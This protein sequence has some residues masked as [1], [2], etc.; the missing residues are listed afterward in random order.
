MPG[1]RTI[2]ETAMKKA[3]SLAWD[4][5]FKEAVN[6]YRRAIEEFPND[7]A[8]RTSLASTLRKLGALNDAIAEY[9]IAIKL[10]PD[11][12]RLLNMLAEVQQQAGNREAAAQTYSRIALLQQREQ[13]LQA[14]VKSFQTAIQLDPKNVDAHVGLSIYY[15]S[16]RQTDAAV[17]ELLTVGRLLALQAKG[18]EAAEYVERALKLSPNNPEAKDLLQRIRDGRV[19]QS[20]PQNQPAP[21][22]P[23]PTNLKPTGSEPGSGRK[24]DFQSIISGNQS[25][26]SIS[27]TS[28]ALPQMPG[29]VAIP[30]MKRKPQPIG[31]AVQNFTQSPEAL[32]QAAQQ[33]EIAGQHYIAIAFHEAIL[34]QVPDNTLS[35]MALGGLYR[36]VEQPEQA[37]RYYYTAMASPRLKRSAM[38]GLG[39]ALREAGKLDET[40]PV[41]EEVANQLDL[42]TLTKEE[43]GEAWA[44]ARALAECYLARGETNK[45]TNVSRIFLEHCTAHG[46]NGLADQIRRWGL[47]LSGYDNGAWWADVQTLPAPERLPAID[48]M[49]RSYELTEAKLWRGAE[50]I[51]LNHI[52]RNPDFLPVHVR[53]GEIYQRQ[54]RN[55][56]ALAKYSNVIDVYAVRGDTTPTIAMYKRVLELTPDNITMRARLAK[57][58][59]D[60]RR[61]EESA[62]ES[63]AV[64]ASYARMGQVE[65]AMDEYRRI[66]NLFPHNSVAYLAYG[67]T[68]NRLGRGA[69]ALQAY[70]QAL[71]LDPN[72]AIAATMVVIGYAIQNEWANIQP[73]FPQVSNAVRTDPATA[74]K[75][76]KEFVDAADFY[77]DNPNLEYCLGAVLVDMNRNAEAIPHFEQAS[78]GNNSERTLLS[79]RV[80]GRCYLDQ[81]QVDQAIIQLR[82]VAQKTHG[83]GVLQMLADAYAQNDDLNESL[84]ALVELR[85][86]SPNDENVRKHLAET[87]FKLGQLNQALAEYESV[88]DMYIQ[89]NQPDQAI[90][91]LQHMVQIAPSNLNV[92][93]RLADLYSQQKQSDKALEVLGELADLQQRQ[94]LTREAAGTLRTMISIVRNLDSKRALV[95][96]QQ[97]VKLMPRDVEARKDLV[98]AYIRIGNPTQAL[99]E[100]AGFAKHLLVQRHM[101]DAIVMLRMAL[102]VDPWNISALEQLAYAQI[103]SGKLS[104]ARDTLQRLSGLAPNNLA[105]A[106]LKAKLE[107]RRGNES[108]DKPIQ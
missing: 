84:N 79:Q 42:P 2:Y 12:L 65:R 64:A 28:V 50:E 41:L 106:A 27:L 70:N 91:T 7:V 21:A 97:I 34:Q 86:I 30:G 87:Y 67:Q 100:A 104:E 32:M 1:N 36:R 75:I 98:Q 31:V 66:I 83:T 88:V 38:A 58:L 52:S 68:L 107:N 90:T 61:F 63:L 56:A 20:P 9:S 69:E 102:Q 62:Q 92:R 103:E 3:D 72:N 23:Q 35:A 17:N 77:P 51:C 13:N 47:A 59:F 49:I 89:N 85:D 82:S 24:I 22:M 96:R 105:A 108:T 73:L 29:G 55:E 14:A 80:L 53:Q 46:W 78:K 18:F 99:A 6:E 43:A 71:T 93:T 60:N 5:K 40:V 10:A 39:L 26:Q 54:Q 44:T 74:Q 11:N 101:D 33:A 57:L 94:N 16:Q 81:G 45:T 15:E 19:R 25:G 95:L 76:L 8:A 48:A 4:R 37:V